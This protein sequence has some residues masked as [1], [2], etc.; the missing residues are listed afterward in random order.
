MKRLLLTIIMAVLVIFLP[1][2]SAKHESK[3]SEYDIIEEGEIISTKDL[4]SS[5][6][7]YVLFEGDQRTPAGIIEV[8]VFFDIIYTSIEVGDTAIYC[9][10]ENWT[11]A[12]LLAICKNDASVNVKEQTIIELAFFDIRDE[13][14]PDKADDA[15]LK[16]MTELGW[17][18]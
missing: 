7:I 8:D 17:V 1:A 10:D 15:T 16:Q 2:C 12:D 13:I 11:D 3:Y 5:G 6:V 14:D 9:R 4:E 18:K